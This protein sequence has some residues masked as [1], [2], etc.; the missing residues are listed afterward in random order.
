MALPKQAHSL[1]RE[2]R[3]QHWGPSQSQEGEVPG[4]PWLHY[5]LQ[6]QFCVL[7][8]WKNRLNNLSA[9]V[10]LLDSLLS[11]ARP[12]KQHL[13]NPST[14]SERK[15][16]CWSFI[17]LTPKSQSS[18]GKNK[19]ALANGVCFRCF[20]QSQCP[21]KHGALPCAHF[22]FGVSANWAP[23]SKNPWAT[24]WLSVGLVALHTW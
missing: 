5:V 13:L 4:E 20:H 6:T 15:N 18:M 24:R 10:F 12:L 17:P 2:A 21:F 22:S 9:L 3:P 16:A 23:D 7:N 19:Q 14:G 8:L 11:F 1:C